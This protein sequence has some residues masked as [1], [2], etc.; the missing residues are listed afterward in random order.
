VTII[1]WWD[2]VLG[3]D[4]DPASRWDP[5][6]KLFSFIGGLHSTGCPCRRRNLFGRIL[7]CVFNVFFLSSEFP[8]S[9]ILTVLT[10]LSLYLQRW[11]CPLVVWWILPQRGTVVPGT[12]A[13]KWC[14]HGLLGWP[15]TLWVWDA[16]VDASIQKE[17][18]CIRLMSTTN[19]SFTL[20]CRLG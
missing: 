2:F 14:W 12:A 15:S 6:R 1:S 11:T 4:P 13:C 20:L 7:W 19:A 16:S 3:P 9:L 5:K 18:G 10:L 17:D 8:S